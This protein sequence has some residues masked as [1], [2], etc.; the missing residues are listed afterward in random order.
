[1]QFVLDNLPL[2]LGASVLASVFLT[3]LYLLLRQRPQEMRLPFLETFW[4]DDRDLKNRK[5]I[6]FR[7]RHWL[8]LLAVILTALAIIWA[9]SG[10]ERKNKTSHVLIAIDDSSSMT[11]NLEK[12][13]R[14]AQAYLAKLGK[15]TYVAV[16]S[17]S[18]QVRPKVGFTQNRA[19][20]SRAIAAVK[21]SDAANDDASLPKF[22]SGLKQKKLALKIFSDRLKPN[23][24]R[25]KQRKHKSQL[26]SFFARRNPADPTQ[27][28]AVA[29]INNPT[30]KTR[31]AQV[32][33][34]AGGQV[35]EKVTAMLAPE[36]TSAIEFDKLNPKSPELEV[37]LNTKGGARDSMVSCIPNRKNLVTALTANA[38]QNEEANRFLVAALAADPRIA[39]DAATK[40]DLVIYDGA[41][42]TSAPDHAGL[43]FV[44]NASVPD[45]L[46]A[47]PENAPVTQIQAPYFSQ[48]FEKD[49]KTMGL[50]DVNI[51]TMQWVAP[52]TNDAIWASFDNKPLIITGQRAGHPFVAVTFDVRESDLVMRPA[53]PLLITR[54]VDFIDHKENILVLP[55]A[56]GQSIDLPPGR[57][58]DQ[59]GAFHSAMFTPMHAGVYRLQN[60][61][62]ELCYAVNTPRSETW[63][64][65]FSTTFLRRINADTKAKV[66][67]SRLYWRWLIFVA[68]LMLMVEFLF[69]LRRRSE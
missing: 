7:V 46:F 8:S 19:A 14:A 6:S 53:F 59:H 28:S 44:H 55:P 12:A 66:A 21:S 67:T 42:P 16:A 39:I 35:L 38:A 62:N 61:D 45:W 36:T 50:R 24:K 49:L 13:K 26:T 41:L 37:I 23:G 4:L 32:E 17:F 48:V 58:V 3:V 51:S 15:S 18:N 20:L 29:S 34:R 43:Y 31:R 11:P 10:L 57:W 40:P 30:K 47:K 68:L 65:P 69:Y 54:F 1:M 25:I 64:T 27:V 56:A 60:E 5:R 63:Q 2:I 22:V 9:A 33:L 52:Q